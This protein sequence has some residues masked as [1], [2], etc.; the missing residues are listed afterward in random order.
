MDDQRMDE[1]IA[2]LLRAG[3]SLAAALVLAGGMW[4]LASSRTLPNY[5]SFQPDM[6]GLSAISALDW[7]EKLI[8]IGLLILIA[9]P[10]ARVA[11]SIA[12]FAAVRDWMYVWFTA[13]V[14]AVLLY[15]IGTA[16][17]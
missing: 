9:T 17:F 14:L 8:G 11:F 7:P 6:K 5:A 16:V 12:A 3:V 4:Y 15:S 10:V 13:I 1:I 2:N